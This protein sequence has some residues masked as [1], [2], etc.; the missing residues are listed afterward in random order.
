MRKRCIEISN[1]GDSGK[2]K[3]NYKSCILNFGF[4]LCHILESENS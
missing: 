2:A 1:K 3:Q 4:S